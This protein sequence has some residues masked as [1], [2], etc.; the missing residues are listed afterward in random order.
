MPPGLLASYPVL[1]EFTYLKILGVLI[2]KSLNEVRDSRALLPISVG[3]VGCEMRKLEEARKSYNKNCDT[4]PGKSMFDFLCRFNELHKFSM[5]AYSVGMHNDQ[6]Q[7]HDESLEN[8]ILF[9][10]DGD[11]LRSSSKHSGRGGSLNPTEFA[12]AL[13]DW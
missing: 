13:L 3:V 12:F 10:I 7:N 6:F 9:T 2:L 8:K 1:A 11:Q 4:T 5:V